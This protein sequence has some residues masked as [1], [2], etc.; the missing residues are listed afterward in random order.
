MVS[1]AN[2][3]KNIWKNLCIFAILKFER[4]KDVFNY[5]LLVALLFFAGAV[6]PSNIF[7]DN[8]NLLPEQIIYWTSVQIFLCVLIFLI[9]N[10]GTKQ[11]KQQKEH[12]HS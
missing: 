1:I 9:I 11:N 6:S 7:D 4:M 5:L 12:K 8:V 10:I 3:N 2:I